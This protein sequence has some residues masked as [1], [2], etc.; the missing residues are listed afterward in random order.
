MAEE[1]LP[2]LPLAKQAAFVEGVGEV[3]ALRRR[4]L[5]YA[6]H[7]RETNLTTTM[8][9]CRRDGVPIPSS[10]TAELVSTL[11]LDAANQ[12]DAE[13]VEVA[14]ETLAG[15]VDAFLDSFFTI[16]E[17]RPAPNGPFSMTSR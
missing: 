9:A 4:M 8:R 13:R 10:V 3:R 15:D 1:L 6:Y 14:L 7:L 5:A 16:P 17:P 12:D 11:H 2:E